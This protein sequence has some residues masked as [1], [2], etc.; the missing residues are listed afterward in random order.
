MSLNLMDMFL[1]VLL[2][3]SWFYV[4]GCGGSQASMRLAKEKYAKLWLQITGESEYAEN[5]F[6]LS[7]QPA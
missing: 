3:G 1:S 6:A 5:T 2:F 7:L 4:L